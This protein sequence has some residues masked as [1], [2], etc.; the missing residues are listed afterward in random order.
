VVRVIIGL[1]GI[2]AATNKVRRHGEGGR[3]ARRGFRGGIAQ[4]LEAGFVDGVLVDDQRIA[5]LDGVFRRGG[6]SGLRG[7]RD[8][9]AEVVVVFIAIV[10]IAHCQRVLLAQLKVDARR[11]IGARE[12]IEERAMV[13]AG[14]GINIDVLCVAPLGAD[15]ERSVLRERSVERSVEL[16]AV[17]VGNVSGERVAGI[18]ALV[19]AH[20]EELAVQ[21]VGAGLGEDFDAPVAEAVKLR[22][23]GVLID[24]DLADRRLGRQIPAREAV[25]VNLAPVWSC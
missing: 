14:G 1:L 2:S 6:G 19:V 18:E 16:V 21:L 10:L 5:Q 25:N 12:G 9:A 11:D 17:I 24:A 7:Q 13:E 22:R 23:V 3:A 20:G 15:E 4:V 8:V